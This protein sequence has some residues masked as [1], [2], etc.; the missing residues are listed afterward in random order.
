MIQVDLLVA[1]TCTLDVIIS[2]HAVNKKRRLMTKA[3]KHKTTKKALRKGKGAKCN[4]L[5]RMIH[6]TKVRDDVFKNCS[7]HRK[8][9]FVI[10][11]QE[12]RAIRGTDTHCIV[13]K[14]D[15]DGNE[16][17][18]FYCHERYVCITQEGPEDLIFG[19][20]TSDVEQQ[21]KSTSDANAKDEERVLLS[22]SLVFH[23]QNRSED[24][25]LVRS[26]GLMVD[27]DN[28][29]A[30]ENVP[31]NNE[32]TQKK[33]GKSQ[34]EVEKNGQQWGWSG[35][36]NR[37]IAGNDI[38]VKPSLPMLFGMEILNLT[39]AELFMK[40]L[41]EEY[42]ENVLLPRTEANMDSPWKVTM[43][44]FQ[45]Y[46]GLWLLIATYGG[47]HGRAEFFATTPVTERH[48]APLRLNQYMSGRR[49]EMI[50]NALQFTDETAPTFEDK[51]WE[52]RQMINKWNK[53]M[54][55]M[56]HSSWV[57]CLDESMSIW[58]NKWSC[59]GW[60]FCPRKPHPFGNEY[61]SIC[62]GQ[63]GVMFK[64]EMVEGN[65]RPPELSKD[66]PN[67]RTIGLLLRLC[68]DLYNRGKVVILDSGF[69]VLEGIIELQKRGVYAGASSFRFFILTFKLLTNTTFSYFH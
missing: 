37:R 69:C 52:V 56:F 34:T 64:I 16:T 24:I 17:N 51:F 19:R 27:D 10:V 61:H 47:C 21:K 39:Y 8:E 59:P 35:L 18:E 22:T 29:P 28:D 58:N 26:Q 30:P 9:K 23:A 63:S 54:T 41:G 25:A 46:L 44:E 45:R 7:F 12:V 20:Q 1:G 65:D 60:V 33:D 67:K 50:T 42:I 4:V 2:V 13:L 43:G 3:T 36:D 5:L 6:P 68:E 62:C 55:K 38:D 32:R 53:N 48:G 57:T 66:P 40:F 49:F 15:T 31:S 11:R 14:R